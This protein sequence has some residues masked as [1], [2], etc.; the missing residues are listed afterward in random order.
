MFS[1]STDRRTPTVDAVTN[2]SGVAPVLLAGF[3]VGASLI[4]AI[5]AQNAYV[6]RQGIRAEHV[7]PIVVICAASDAIL[8]LAGV[9]GIG[10]IVD[11]APHTLV[12]LRWAAAAFLVGYGLLAARRAFTTRSLTAAGGSSLRSAV[13][14]VLAMT[15][16]NPHV[17]LDTVLLL[18][19]IANTQAAGGRWYFG[20]G[21]A[22]ASV[23]WFTALGYGARLLSRTLARSL[24]W[25]ILDGIIAATMLALGVHLTIDALP[26][27]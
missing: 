6:L 1:W 4:V 17:Y 7:L 20:A 15:W 14:T 16:L 19:S 11:R 10:A 26:A 24:A 8:I 13:L 18:G 22:L 2:I 5:G 23:A 3:G 25:R 21:A 27:T 9:T 12:V